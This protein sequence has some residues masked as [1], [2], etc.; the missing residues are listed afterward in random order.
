LAED[1]DLDTKAGLDAVAGLVGMNSGGLNAPQMAQA[2]LAPGHWSL[3]L[4]RQAL[5]TQRLP[6]DLNLA[7][8]HLAA[9]RTKAF[10]CQ[11]L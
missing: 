11:N 2:A 9:W 6:S 10:F 5:H 8:L 3:Y 1:A 4:H 7:P